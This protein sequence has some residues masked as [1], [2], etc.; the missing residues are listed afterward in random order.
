MNIAAKTPAIQI[1]I[2]N[3]LLSRADVVAVVFAARKQ[4]A[5]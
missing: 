3:A 4:V 2:P 1:Q 5:L